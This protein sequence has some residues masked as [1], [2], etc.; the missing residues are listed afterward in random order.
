VDPNLSGC[1]SQAAK[2]EKYVRKYG[3]NSLD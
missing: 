2:G 3:Q 1:R